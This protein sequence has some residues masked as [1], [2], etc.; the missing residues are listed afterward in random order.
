MTALSKYQRLE[1]PGLW[2]ESH[3]AQR[4]NIVASLGK[5]T[6]TISD[7][8]DRVLAHWSLAAII[9]L[10]PGQRPAHFAPGP[11]GEPRARASS[12]AAPDAAPDAPPE[13]SS[14]LELEDDAL[15]SALEKVHAVIEKRRPHHGRLRQ[16][17]TSTMLAAL[18]GIAVFWLPDALVSYTVNVV[19]Q[20]SRAALGT[21]LVSRIH[22][23]AGRAC[24]EP[25]ASQALADLGQKLLGENPARLIVLAGASKPALHL[26][27]PIIL[28]NHNLIS[29]YDSA[30]VVAGFILT[31]ATRAE[32]TDPMLALLNHAGLAATIRLLTTG[33]MTDA[34][35]DRYSETL[36]TNAPPPPPGIDI[37]DRFHA[38]GQPASPY[39]FALDPTGETT[40]ALIEADPIKLAQ[41]QPPISD[42]QWISLQ[43][44]CEN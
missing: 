31:E 41:A 19:P 37:L 38:A 23:V 40:L 21:R 10:N 4:V 1:A 39:A 13:T 28:I 42:S 26:P 15:I 29:A 44:I 3:D 24:T 18:T 32:Q 16:F 9:R 6:L 36:L 22:R 43:G 12:R 35:L 7:M 17:V 8:S 25:V 33:D 11:V 2:H 34:V 27:G 14:V 5:A 30:Y 20:A